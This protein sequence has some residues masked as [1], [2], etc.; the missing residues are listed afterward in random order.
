[1]KNLLFVGFALVA[2]AFIALAISNLPGCTSLVDCW[3]ALGEA[4]DN[5]ADLPL[6][7]KILMILGMGVIAAWLVLFIKSALRK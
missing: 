5:W 2:L 1:M 4:P 3:E 6:S 7:A